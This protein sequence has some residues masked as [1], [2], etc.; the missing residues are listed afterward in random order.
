MVLPVTTGRSQHVIK[1]K[2]SSITSLLTHALFGLCCFYV[3]LL[4]G[5][6]TSSTVETPKCPAC[7]TAKCPPCDTKSA[8]DSANAF[9]KVVKESAETPISNHSFPPTLSRMFV[10]FGTIPRD[11]FNQMI[12]VGVPLDDTTK[13]AEDVLVLFPQNTQP[14]HASHGLVGVNAQDALEHCNTLKLILTEPNKQHCFA[15]LPQWESY[16]VHKYMRLPKSGPISSQAPLRY[17][18]RS[19]ADK[20]TSQKV[21][22]YKLHTTPFFAVLKDYLEHLP[23]LLEDLKPILEHA[24][25]DGAGKS[26]LVQV[27]N[28]GQVEL[29]HNF[30]CTAKARGIEDF[31][32][33]MIMFATDEATYELCQKLGIPAFYDANI[34]GDLPEQAAR[35]YG[36]RTFSKMMM[37]KVYCVQL[38]L[39]LGYNVLFQDVDV[40]WYKNPLKYFEDPDVQEWDMMFQDDGARSIR[41]APYSPN[42]GKYKRVI[43][44]FLSIFTVQYDSHNCFSFRILFCSSQCRNCLFL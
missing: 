16:Y 40:V 36:D 31:G 7:P 15:F 8:A 27:C 3:G 6:T 44:L 39:S 21:P 28:Y 1:H 37:A 34:F 2:K 9:L 11:N 25:G 23:R 24:A 22:D 38:V 35:G 19:H 14:N 12:D 17:V 29:F 33:N 5:M 42:T 30:V 10:D 13:G 32:Q 41:Y 20:G 4:V 43:V 18:S 26:L